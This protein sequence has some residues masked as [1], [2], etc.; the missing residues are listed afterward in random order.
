MSVAQKR[1]GN[2]SPAPAAR[3]PRAPPSLP[4]ETGEVRE[5]R[6]AMPGGRNFQ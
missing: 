3:R 5:I 2:R 6:K 4:L 1:Q